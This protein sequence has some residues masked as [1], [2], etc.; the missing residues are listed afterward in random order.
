MLR[1]EICYNKAYGAL[2]LKP[3]AHWRSADPRN[4]FSRK[5]GKSRSL[6]S[7]S[8]GRL[9]DYPLFLEGGGQLIRDKSGEVLGAVGVTG[10]AN[11]LDDICA[12]TGIHTA[13]PCS[14]SD[15]FDDRGLMRALSIHKSAP[16]TDPRPKRLARQPAGM[17]AGR[18]GRAAGKPPKTPN[19]GRNLR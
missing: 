12:V 18:N 1:L 15:F 11:E 4:L 9:A 17:R 3:M 6:C 14:D 7:H 5:R 2:A 10:D 19:P 13:R 16:L 8:R